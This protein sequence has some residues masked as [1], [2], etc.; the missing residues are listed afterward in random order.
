MSSRRH[1]VANGPRIIFVPAADV[2]TAKGTP[3]GWRPA[4]SDDEAARYGWRLIGANN[5]ELGRSPS[6]Y[7][8][9][10]EARSNASALKSRAFELSEQIENDPKNGSWGWRASL[11]GAVVAASGRGYQRQRE[12][13][14]NFRQFVVGLVAAVENLSPVTPLRVRVRRYTTTTVPARLEQNPPFQPAVPK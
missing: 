6:T 2:E 5:R 7:A 12:C 1:V 11:D 10:S 3:G 4:G 13:S 14:Y 8:D 9:L